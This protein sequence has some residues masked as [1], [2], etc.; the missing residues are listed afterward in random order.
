PTT[1][2]ERDR[3]GPEQADVEIAGRPRGGEGAGGGQEPPDDR[4]RARALRVALGPRGGHL[5]ATPPAGGVATDAAR[6][7]GRR[8]GTVP[9]GLRA[10]RLGRTAVAGRG[11]DAG[12]RRRTRPGAHRPVRVDRAPVPRDAGGRWRGRPA[13]PGCR[14]R[15]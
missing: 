1:T 9:E 2:G 7:G 12:S 6:S 5:P 4:T 15:A 11:L 3:H 13:P 8:A 14:A 10:G